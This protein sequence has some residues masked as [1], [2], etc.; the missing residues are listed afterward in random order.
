MCEH[1]FDVP[2]AFCLKNKQENKQTKTQLTSLSSLSPKY[3]RIKN[4][5]GP[6]S[7]PHIFQECRRTWLIH[8]SNLKNEAY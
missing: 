8:F 3:L 1:V 5:N 4:T 6:P 2:N 7:K